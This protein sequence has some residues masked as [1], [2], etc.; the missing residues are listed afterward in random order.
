M[1]LICCICTGIKNTALVLKSFFDI[2]SCLWP[3]FY[4]IKPQ[5]PIMA[6]IKT[7]WQWI[8]EIEGYITRITPT[9][10]N[11]RRLFFLCSFSNISQSPCHCY[12]WWLERTVPLAACP[13]NSF[14]TEENRAPLANRAAKNSAVNLDFGGKWTDRSGGVSSVCEQRCMS[15]DPLQHSCVPSNLLQKTQAWASDLPLKFHQIVSACRG[16]K[17]KYPKLHLQNHKHYFRPPS[18]RRKRAFVI[19]ILV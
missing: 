16:C 15:V 18:G 1:H 6:L 11:V 3:D 13:F 5:H 12:I 17:R 10:N 7:K 14:N 19:C 9:L 4:K 2:Y 8:V